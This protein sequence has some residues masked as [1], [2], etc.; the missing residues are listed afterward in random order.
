MSLRTLSK[1]SALPALLAL[2]CGGTPE[3]RLAEPAPVR[4]PLGVAERTAAA[5]ST[6]LSGFVQADRTA[7]VSTRVMA[8]VTAVHVRL[9]DRVD[10]GQALVSIDPTAAQGQASQ[11]AGAVTQAEAAL[12]L[13]ERN[14]ERYQALA[15]TNAASELELDMARSQY[16]QARGAVEQARGAAQSARSVAGDSRVTAPFAG[17][18]A[19]RYVEVGDL[20][21]P[22]RPLVLL[23]SE[24]GRQLTLAVPETLMARTDL[25]IGTPIAVTLD[26][27][28]DLGRLEGTVV[29]VSPG[30][31]P[32]SHSF[33]VKLTLPAGD[34][35]AGSAARAFLPAVERE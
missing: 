7:A 1:L 25:A 34:L 3:A 20:A 32:A 21:A 14:Y 15:A 31:D 10:A 9:G 28:P 29:E 12:A 19:Q 23:E 2:A 27:L 17:R 4:A 11:A 8:M 6:E 33:T 30:P 18:I 35:P 13:A 16:E 26:A 24:R 5:G 22:G